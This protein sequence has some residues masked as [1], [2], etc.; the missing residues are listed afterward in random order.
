MLM[1][2]CR[3]DTAR[4]IG[5]FLASSVLFGEN[6]ARFGGFCLEVLFFLLHAHC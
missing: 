4:V 6:M 1:T 2:F 3:E 5:M